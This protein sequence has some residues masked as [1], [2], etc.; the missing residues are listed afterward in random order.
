VTSS[1]DA[2]AEREI[3]N[4]LRRAS[5]S[6]TTLIVAHRLSSIIHCDRIIVIENGGIVE[7]GTHK[8]LLAK[9]GGLYRRMWNAQNNESANTGTITTNLGV[10][11]PTV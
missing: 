10:R 11:V 6:R 3:V 1:V 2:F 4:T 7:Q 9:D 5:S 8:S